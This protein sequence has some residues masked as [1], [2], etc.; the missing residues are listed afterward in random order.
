MKRTKVC[1]CCRHEAASLLVPVCVRCGEA[2]W[3]TIVDIEDLDPPPPK[4]RKRNAG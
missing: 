1:I 2:S 4:K 3:I